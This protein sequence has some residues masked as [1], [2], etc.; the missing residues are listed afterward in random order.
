VEVQPQLTDEFTIFSDQA[1]GCICTLH[2]ISKIDD[3]LSVIMHKQD[4][5]IALS[6]ILIPSNQKL[7]H[8]LVKKRHHYCCYRSFYTI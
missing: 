3:I 2:L 6:V 4:W 5:N 8:H 1:T 7:V